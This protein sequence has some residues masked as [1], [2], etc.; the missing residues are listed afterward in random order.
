MASKL[1]YFQTGNKD[2]TLLQNTWSAI[3]NPVVQ[4]E[5][6]NSNILKSVSLVS[7]SNSVNHLLG[8]KLQ[9]WHIVRQ[10]AAATFYD[11]QDSNTMPDLTL[12]LTASGNVVVDILVF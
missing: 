8:R 10:R 2:L 7:G 11:T 3:L 4:A 1:P 6:V 5:I 12:L 9:G